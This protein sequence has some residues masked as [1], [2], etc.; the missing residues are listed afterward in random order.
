VQHTDAVRE[1]S[2]AENKSRRL[3]E[4]LAAAEAEKGDLRSQLAEERRD[5]NKAI[6]DAQAAQAE[7]KLAWAE[8]S[9]ARQRA[10]ELEARLNSLRNRVDKTEVST[11]AE[12]ETH[13]QF[14]VAYQELGAR[15]AAFEA[16]GQEVGLRFL[17][18]LQEELGVLQTIVT[19]LMSFASLVTC[20]GAVNALSCEG[21]GH[22]EVFDQSDE[23]F[24]HEIFQVEDPVLKQS[25]G[26]LFDRMWG[27]HGRETVRERF[28]R[29]MDQVK[30]HL[31]GYM[32]GYVWVCVVL[33]NECAI[34]ADRT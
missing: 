19:G 10:E 17:E 32:C 27:P 25:A 20:E 31:C 28:D 8:T 4:R 26:A 30:A 3:T 15:T 7:A 14:V 24:E 13:A 1:K 21:C 9:P 29:A 33:L 22:F 12:V 16:P 6:A 34:S 11:R 2:A 5:A 23:G 18:W